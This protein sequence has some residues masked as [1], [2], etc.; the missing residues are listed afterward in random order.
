MKKVLLSM[1]FFS[2]SIGLFAGDLL[3][4]EFIITPSGSEQI[5]I[6]NSSGSSINLLAY[7]LIISGSG[8]ADTFSLP[9]SDITAGGYFILNSG[10]V[11]W[12]NLPNEGATFMI[13]GPSSIEDSVGYGSYG[14]APAPIYQYSAARV[15]TTGDN[16]V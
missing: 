9:N 11:A 2:L 7:D 4:N 12:T 15:N 13:L 8:W 6:Y 14:G 16:A 1:V 5:E 10:N 3:I